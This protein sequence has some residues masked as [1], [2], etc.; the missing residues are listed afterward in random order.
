[1]P[2]KKRPQRDDFSEVEFRDFLKTSLR[3]FVL[4]RLDRVDVH[5]QLLD[6]LPSQDEEVQIVVAHAAVDG[7]QGVGERQPVG[8]DVVE[9]LLRV[10]MGR[11]HE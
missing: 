1:M 11:R 2:R 9:L 3:N 10:P 4:D 7:I 8:Q 5:P 6:H